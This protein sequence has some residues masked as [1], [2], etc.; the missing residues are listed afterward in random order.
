[1]DLIQREGHYPVP[2]QAP[3]TLGV[4]FSGTVE[5]LGPEAD[6]SFAPGDSVFGLAYGGAYAQYVAVA[7]AMLLDRTRVALASEMMTKQTGPMDRSYAKFQT[8]I[9]DDS[10]QMTPPGRPGTQSRMPMMNIR[11]A[12]TSRPA[13]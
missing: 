4:E 8:S 10:V 3:S 9:S 5:A 12:R 6:G 11:I 7:T 2:P 13:L 1:M